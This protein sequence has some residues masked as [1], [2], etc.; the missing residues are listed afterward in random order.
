LG[1]LIAALGPFLTGTV[2]GWTGGWTVPLWLLL[3]LVVPLCAV[4]VYAGRPAYL[5]DQLA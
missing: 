2:Y 4:G 5:E 1:Y 3:A